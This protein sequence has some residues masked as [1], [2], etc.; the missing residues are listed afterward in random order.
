MKEYPGWIELL[1][2]SA[3][4]KNC[5]EGEYAPFRQDMWKDEIRSRMEGV[6]NAGRD[7]RSAALAELCS[8]D[9][10]RLSS[11]IMCLIVVG[12]PGDASHIE[13]LT[14]HA[15]EY[16][17]KAAKSCLFELRRKKRAQKGPTTP[18]T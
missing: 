17:R 2:K 12:K 13:Q 8:E 14:S 10:Y 4:G 9:L 6:P 1:F 5:F 3:V 16:I 15:N 18:C 7:L 11:A